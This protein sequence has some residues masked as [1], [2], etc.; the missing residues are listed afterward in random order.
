MQISTERLFARVAPLRTRGA[1]GLIWVLVSLVASFCGWA[2]WATLD[3]QV[4]AGGK[5][6]ASSRSQVV[7]AVDGGV[8][9]SSKVREGS[10]VRKGDVLVTLDPARF[11]SRVE[12]TRVQ[13]LSLLANIARLEAE[14]SGSDVQFPPEV[15]DDAALVRVQRDLYARRRQQ[16]DEA[17][18]TLKRSLKLAEAELA[19]LENLSRT[20][21][22]GT[23][24]VLRA[25]R[26]VSE[27][28]GQLTNEINAYRQEAQQNLANARGELDQVREVLKQRQEAL[29]A[30]EIRAPMA[31]TIKSIKVF[32]Q[33]A[34]LAPGDEVLQIV[35]S[36]EPLLV[37]ARVRS[38][39]VAFVRPGLRANV[40]LDA[41]DFTIYGALKGEVSYVSPDI[42]DAGLQRDE[43]PYYRVLVEITDPLPREGQSL[44]VIPGMSALVEIITGDRTVAQYILKPLLRGNAAAL[45]ER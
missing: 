40:K 32:T 36:D 20:G 18:A 19:S 24:E 27:L 14:L 7:Q 16:V 42:I 17:Q 5:V 9:M 30:T 23:S 37:E 4:R 25:Q 10:V 22:A 35:P 29:S 15:L 41:Y 13:S 31:G 11:A 39:D 33:G 12:E 8:L 1:D 26:A 2:A 45:T 38:K 43:E 3:E 34:V 44:E 6:I 21:D 28:R